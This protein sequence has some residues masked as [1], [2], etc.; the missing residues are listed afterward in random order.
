MQM[1]NQYDFG[2]RLAKSQLPSSKVV[3]LRINAFNDMGMG[4]NPGT[5]GEPQVI[6][7]IYGCE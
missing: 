6:A 4:Q 5:S 1:L 7:G 3:N 2:A